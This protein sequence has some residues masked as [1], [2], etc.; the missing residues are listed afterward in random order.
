M[1]DSSDTTGADPRVTRSV[2]SVLDATVALLLDGGVHAT[3]VDAIAERSGVSKATIYRHWDSRQE[4]VI[5][6]LARLKPDSPAPD[7]GTVRGDLVEIT[8]GL[9]GH[10]GSPAAAAFTSM[11]GAAEHD[12]RLAELRLSFTAARRR[13][14]EAVIVRA[15][16]RG[17]LPSDLDVDLFLATV[18]GPLFYRRVIQGRPVPTDWAERTVD[19]V[20]AAYGVDV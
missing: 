15:I 19:A 8:T 12:P 2:A 6:A 7:T 11:S 14:A 4:L 9:V 18:I 13:P 20:L 1:T 16:E 5:E 10:L 3:T 17:E